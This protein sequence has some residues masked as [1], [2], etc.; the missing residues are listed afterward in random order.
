MPIIYTDQLLSSNGDGTPNPYSMTPAAIYGGIRDFSTILD[1]IKNGEIQTN[2][3]VPYPV[4]WTNT[5]NGDNPPWITDP[6]DKSNPWSGM[7]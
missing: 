7:Y 2:T 6:H 1:A 5:E 4:N 3:G